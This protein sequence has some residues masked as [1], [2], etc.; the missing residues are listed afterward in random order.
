MVGSAQAAVVLTPSKDT[1]INS[2]SA[3]TIY[4]N[5]TFMVTNSNGTSFRYAI[6]S[7]D[8]STVNFAVGGVKL[9]LF[10]VAGNA[11]TKQYQIFG[12]LAAHDGWIETGTGALTWDNS[13]AFR[14]GNTIDLTQVY[15]GAAL[16]T[17][18]T[19]QNSLFTA[20]DVSSG[21]HVDFINANRS[22]N[23]G[24]NIVTYIIADPLVELLGTGWATKE[25]ATQPAATLTLIPEPSTALLG[26]LGLLAL[27]RR[28]R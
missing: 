16:G 10:D 14:D 5:D 27:L 1:Y 17:F 11:G 23:G 21:A 26:V 7:Y 9:E 19:A 8:I 13:T 2:A 6:F 25:N 20:F 15:G 4:G 24:N 3:S 18:N 12:L 22:A 28:R